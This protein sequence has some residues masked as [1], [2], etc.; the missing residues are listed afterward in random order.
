MFLGSGFACFVFI[1]YLL[2]RQK[3]K[4]RK[5]ES[6]HPVATPANACSGRPGLRWSQEPGVQSR[7]PSGV[8]VSR[9]CWCRLCVHRTE[10]EGR[11]QKH[12]VA[13]GH[14]SHSLG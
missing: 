3:E 11:A 5:K 8:P 7:K 1:F 10:A 12:S 14:L 2:E 13:H 9:G 6:H 4:I